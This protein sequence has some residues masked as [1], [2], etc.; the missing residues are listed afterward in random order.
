MFQ[1]IWEFDLLIIRRTNLH[2]A[3]VIL[4]TYSS[5]SCVGIQKFFH[6][7]RGQ[8]SRKGQGHSDKRLLS[9][10]CFLFFIHL[11][12]R[13]MQGRELSPCDEERGRRSYFTCWYQDLGKINRSNDITCVRDKVHQL[14]LKTSKMPRKLFNTLIF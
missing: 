13:I 9:R 4:W 12:T 7:K 1:M 5:N 2:V 8:T 11:W 10:K 3:S 6:S 14:M